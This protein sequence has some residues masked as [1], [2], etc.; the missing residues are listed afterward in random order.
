VTLAQNVD[1]A[2]TCDD[3]AEGLSLLQRSAGKQA[4]VAR[5]D[6]AQCNNTRPTQVFMDVDDTYM[7]SGGQWPAGCEGIYGKHVIFPGMAQFVLE[8]TRGPNEALK[9]LQPALM[10]AR[11]DGIDIL[12]IHQDSFQDV[13]MSSRQSSSD[14]AD[15]D[16]LNA[17][18][19][20]LI[21]PGLQSYRYQDGGIYQI[22]NGS[23]RGAGFGLDTSGSKYGA[24]GDFAN[25]EKMGLT[26]YH[27]FTDYFQGTVKDV[28]E[29]CVVFIGDDG[30]GD[31]HPAA[32]KMRRFVKG[33]KEEL[34]LK[35]AFIH[36]L[37]C[38]DKPVCSNHT[39]QAGEAPVF[40]FSTYMDAARI[41]AQH[42]YISPDAVQRVKKEVQSFFAVYC[43][44]ERTKVPETLSDRGCLELSKSLQKDGEEISAK[45]ALS[46]RA[47]DR[48]KAYCGKCCKGTFSSGSSTFKF[49][50]K[51]FRCHNMYHTTSWWRVWGSQASNGDCTS[52]CA[53]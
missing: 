22:L 14:P 46:F 31:C 7:S 28:D 1:L 52:H 34:G 15:W 25:S 47:A 48:F 4:S 39:E 41:A 3:E 9:V 45:P 2:G 37:E 33:G 10:S 24:L 5:S 20:L 40:M 30:Q 51:N 16:S 8:L 26:K 23:T 32:E 17:D 43:D 53:D 29:S 49:D 11:P 44:K 50:G 19:K 21:P 6:V 42:G 12:R 38:S 13:A 35:A 18:M 36:K 27:G